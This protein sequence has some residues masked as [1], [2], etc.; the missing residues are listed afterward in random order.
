MQACAPVFADWQMRLYA[1][2]G[3]PE[4]GLAGIEKHYHDL[5]ERY[6]C[7]VRRP[8]NLV[9]Q[10]ATNDGAEEAGRSH[11]RVP[12]ECGTL[13]DRP[14]LRQPRR[15]FENAGKLDAAIQN[16]EKAIAQGSQIGDRTSIST[17]NT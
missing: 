1:Q 6:G 14:S 3:G 5:T 12:A 17:K 7:A 16:I 15:R 4:G 8:K 10:S 2:D 9:N 13:S 11:S